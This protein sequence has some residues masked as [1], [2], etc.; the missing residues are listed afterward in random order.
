M[1]N[2]AYQQLRE[3]LW[4]YKYK[5]VLGEA[6][7][8]LRF[9]QPETTDYGAT[10]LELVQ[11][12]AEKLLLAGKQKDAAERAR[13]ETIDVL[14]NKLVDVTN[15][16]KEAQLRIAATEDYATALEFRAQ[17]VEVRL[18]RANEE[19]AAVEQAIRTRL[20]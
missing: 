6:D 10:A 14:N 16:L 4:E 9:S 11:Q 3:D 17:A 13:M 15:A 5:S 18:S 20:L 12:A 19:L 1:R 8:V 2:P 7:N